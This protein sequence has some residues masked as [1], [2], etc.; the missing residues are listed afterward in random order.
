M[1]PELPGRRPARDVAP[2]TR[3]RLPDLALKLLLQGGILPRF[4][5]KPPPRS[6]VKPRQ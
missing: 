1:H 4:I 2:D 3:L 6:Q 5:G